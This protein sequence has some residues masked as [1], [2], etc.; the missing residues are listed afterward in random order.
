MAQSINGGE[1][2]WVISADTEQFDQ[3]LQKAKDS[4]NLLTAELSKL[5][6]LEWLQK[7]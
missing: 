6:W 4:A 1:V 7:V 2:R 3:A 5:Q